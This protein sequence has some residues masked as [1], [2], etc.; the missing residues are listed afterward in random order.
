MVLSFDV[1]FCSQI[2][3][4]FLQKIEKNIFLQWK[5]KKSGINIFS[6]F[7]DFSNFFVLEISVNTK[8]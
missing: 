8:N 3:K 7:T 4:F 6:I 1:S 5:S 2:E